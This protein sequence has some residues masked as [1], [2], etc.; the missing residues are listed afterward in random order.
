MLFVLRLLPP[1]R[2]WQER[3]IFVAFFFN[4]AITLIATVSFS[5][6]C[7]PFAAIYKS[8]PHA[9]CVSER[10]LVITMQVN[11]SESC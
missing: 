7:R 9:T 11:A 1:N 6:R 4:F 8:V 2:K 3:A 5:L 10:V